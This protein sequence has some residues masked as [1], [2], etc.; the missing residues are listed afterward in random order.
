MTISHR[1]LSRAQGSVRRPGVLGAGAIASL[2]LAACSDQRIGDEHSIDAGTAIFV[3]A[4]ASGSDSGGSWSSAH[5]DL[6]AAIDHA[7]PGDEIWVRAGTYRP[8]GGAGHREATFR[9][10]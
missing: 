1:S 8:A 4:A 3:D 9:L 10:K 2:V 7:R 6:Q 5:H